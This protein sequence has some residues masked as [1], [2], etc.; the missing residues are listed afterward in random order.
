MDEGQDVEAVL[1]GKDRQVAGV[2]DD[3]VH[4]EIGQ[5]EHHAH[6]TDVGRRLGVEVQGEVVVEDVVAR[7]AGG[8]LAQILVGPSEQLGA[9]QAAQAVVGG[10]FAGGG[11]G[12]CQERGCQQDGNERLKSGLHMIL[13]DRVREAHSIDRGP[14]R[15]QPRPWKPGKNTGGSVGISPYRRWRTWPW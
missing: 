3:A 9:G 2:Q 15:E 11:E 7:G 5:R 10:V 13:H 6:A 1:D 14:C 12:R 8:Q 4:F